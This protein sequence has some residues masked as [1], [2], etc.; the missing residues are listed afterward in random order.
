M[1]AMD[2]HF[3]SEVIRNA[4]ANLFEIAKGEDRPSSVNDL[5]DYF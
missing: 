4:G 1:T 3:C 5:F 2:L